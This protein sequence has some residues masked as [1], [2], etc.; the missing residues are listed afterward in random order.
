MHQ[1]S[2]VPAQKY[3]EGLYDELCHNV[4]RIRQAPQPVYFVEMF[5]D[6]DE[7]T[8]RPVFN[9][10]TYPWHVFLTTSLIIS[11]S[12][13]GTLS[14]CRWAWLLGLPDAVFDGST[15]DILSCT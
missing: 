1:S 4:A 9:H 6:V 15:G 11:W 3:L 2:A 8:G 7:T 10:G 13:V 12:R 5:M 14:H